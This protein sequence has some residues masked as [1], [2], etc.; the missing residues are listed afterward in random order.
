M[1]SMTPVRTIMVASMPVVASL[2]AFRDAL[3]VACSLV[4]SVVGVMVPPVVMVPVLADCPLFLFASA[5]FCAS[6]LA[7]AS[8]CALTA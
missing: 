3:S 8:F 7:C 4:L 5:F 6:S 1:A 2:S